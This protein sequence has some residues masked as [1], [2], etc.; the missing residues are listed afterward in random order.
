MFS[1]SVLLVLFIFTGGIFLFLAQ[2]G[3]F[4]QPRRH[5]A[6]DGIGGNSP[7]SSRSPAS[8]PISKRH[9]LVH[10]IDGIQVEAPRLHRL[11]QVLAQ[12]QVDDIVGAAG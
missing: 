6:I 9:G 10:M 7:C 11:H 8:M 12:H 2:A 4:P 5:P 3:K 1:H